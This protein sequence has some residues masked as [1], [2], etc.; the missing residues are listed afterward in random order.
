MRLDPLIASRKF[1]LPAVSTEPVFHP[2]LRALLDNRGHLGA[3]ASPHV[4]IAPQRLPISH[5]AKVHGR[6]NQ[7]PVESQVHAAHG[8]QRPLQCTTNDNWHTI[9]AAT[10]QFLWR[11]SERKPPYSKG[12]FSRIMSRS[13]ISTLGMVSTAST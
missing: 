4:V 10:A 6:A 3:P 7:I 5:E 9:V 8:E 13:F 11:D 1:T 2:H 12:L